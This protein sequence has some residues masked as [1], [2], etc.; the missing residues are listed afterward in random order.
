MGEL[1][2]GG[3]DD[4]NG[5]RSEWGNGMVYVGRVSVD[6][7]VVKRVCGEKVTIKWQT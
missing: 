3:L 5:A 2:R 7:D 4:V 1:V 6:W